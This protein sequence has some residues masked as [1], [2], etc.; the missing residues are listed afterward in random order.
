MPWLEELEIGWYWLFFLPR[1][2]LCWILSSLEVME[3]IFLASHFWTIWQQSWPPKCIG[4][5]THSSLPY[6]PSPRHCPVTLGCSRWEQ[7]HQWLE[8]GVLMST[9]VTPLWWLKKAFGLGVVILGACSVKLT[10]DHPCHFWPSFRRGLLSRPGRVK[11][12]TD[13]NI[14]RAVSPQN[15]KTRE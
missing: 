8:V 12:N 3:V 5:W 15:H 10:P 11:T 2:C 7:I 4:P 13:L 1:V 6:N 9:S 14:L